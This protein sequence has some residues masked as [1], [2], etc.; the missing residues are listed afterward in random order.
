VTFST[1]DRIAAGLFVLALA[2]T[3]AVPFPSRAFLYDYRA[4][5]CAGRIAGT[6]ADPY[7]TE[8]LRTCERRSGL[9]AG[10]KDLAR[11]AVPAPLPGYALAPFALLGRLPDV[12]GAALWL[13]ISLLGA[14]LAIRSLIVVARVPPRIVWL[15]LALPL[16]VAL[17]LGQLVPL[18]LGALCFAALALERGR[19]GLA[20]AAAWVAMIEPHVA[21]PALLAL[22]I[23]VPRARLGVGIGAIVAL[24]LSLA[25]LGI[26]KNVEY[27]ASVLPAHAV[28]ELANEEQYSLA[29]LLHFLGAPDAFALRAAELWYVVLLAAGLFVAQRLVSHGAPRA[30]YVLLPAAFAVAGGPFVHVQQ[31]VF[32]APAL[33]VIAGRVAPR[34]RAVALA[35]ILLAVPWGA[36]SLLLVATPLVAFVIGMSSG[37]LLRTRPLAAT[38]TGLLA[39]AFVA[40]LAQSL[41]PRPDATAALAPYADGRLLAEASW[42]AYMRSSFHQNLGIFALAKVPTLA[43]LALGLALAVRAALAHRAA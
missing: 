7:R 22:A 32:A 34:A 15:T 38:V 6:A 23:F 30:L 20:A 11:L 26:G 37:S 4:F 39:A 41:V 9:L 21:L 5:A 10:R 43:G 17:V 18:A 24:V 27:L 13:L 42:A 3:R 28:S 19:Y 29:A 36:F 33:L 31:M 12:V 35:L 1:R 16:A 14:F 2:L 40:I 8:P 25:L